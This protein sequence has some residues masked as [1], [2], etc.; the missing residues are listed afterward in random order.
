MRLRSRG[1][2]RPSSTTVRGPRMRNSTG[3]VIFVALLVLAEQGSLV[4]GRLVGHGNLAAVHSRSNDLP[5]RA[6]RG[7]TSM[8]LDGDLVAG[9]GRRSP[10]GA[11]RPTSRD[12]TPVGPARDSVFF[13]SG[14][15]SRH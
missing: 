7:Q 3:I 14:T 4:R 2:C 15:R 13:G 9:K 5:A 6:A 11:R 8:L 10:T 12:R 1:T